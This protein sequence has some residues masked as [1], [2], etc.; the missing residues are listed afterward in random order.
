M[1]VADLPPRGTTR[2]VARRKRAVVHGVRSGLLT[3]EDALERYDL[4]KEEFAAWEAA[5]ARHGLS[6]LK[7]TRIQEFRG[8]S[9]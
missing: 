9:T 5:E 1:S 8:G 2:W 7:A 4:S 3:L 6:G